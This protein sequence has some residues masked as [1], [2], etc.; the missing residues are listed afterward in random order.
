MAQGAQTVAQKTW[1]Y[2]WVILF[3]VWLLYLI[4]YFDRISVLT[5]L[6]Y[7][8]KDLGLN[9]VEIGWLGSIFFFGYAIAQFFAGFLADK[10][11]PKK[12]MN[13]AIW[14]FTAVTF[15]TGFVRTF[16][17]FII[18]RLALALGEGN[19]YVP[20]VR[21]I[22]NW[23]PMQEKGRANG[24]FATTWAVAPAIVP[25][26]VTWM[27]ADLFDGAW[28]PV[29]FVL[30][31]PGILGVFLLWKYM[32][33]TPREMLEKGKVTKEEYELITS[34]IGADASVHGKTYSTRIFTTDPQYYL[35]TIT[36]FTLLM[37]Y[38]G[39]TTWISTFLVKM[40]GLN[41]KTMGFYASMPFIVAFFAMWAGGQVADKFF[42]G[43]MKMVTIIGFLGCIPVLYFIG[44]SPKGDAGQLL[45]WLGMGGFFI[46]FPWGV[47]QAF[48]S[49]RYP[50]E[51]VGRAMGITNGVGQFGAFI[52][53]VLAGYLVVTLPDGSFN[54]ANVFIF[55]SALAAVAS[56]AAFM[57]AEKPVDHSKFE[58]AG[59]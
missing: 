41:I 59:K 14:V 28:R 3:V 30:A 53:P 20:A 56:V 27:S 52:S 5:F 8:Q 45:F 25:I 39:M 38:W 42:K 37:I 21:A 11:G 4:N 48:P 22:A 18:L 43:R 16:W 19:H 50:K 36:F 32:S 12:T 55:W 46:N 44:Q 33:D 51:V 1:G 13:I 15:V 58:I 29:F 47:M 6:P 49:V 17:Q 10:F 7:I 26:A 57:L 24:Y 40:H 31:V 23:F 35:F 9:A 2:R 34:S 54:F